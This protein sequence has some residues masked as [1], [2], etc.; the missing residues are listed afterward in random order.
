MTNNIALALRSRTATAVKQPMVD[1]ADSIL[2]EP[3]QIKDGTAVIPA[4]PGN[5]LGWNDEAAARYR[6]T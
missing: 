4:R 5:G 3:L 2:Q 1:W 6:L